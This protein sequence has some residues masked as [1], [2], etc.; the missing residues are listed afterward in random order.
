MC[1]FAV[2]IPVIR[3]RIQKFLASEPYTFTN[4]DGV[5]AL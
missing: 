1:S 2:F 5:Y 4:I 3:G